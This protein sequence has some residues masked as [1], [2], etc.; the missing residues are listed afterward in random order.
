MLDGTTAVGQYIRSG[1][2]MVIYGGMGECAY[3]ANGAG[4]NICVVEPC[5]ASAWVFSI[6]LQ[7]GT[8]PIGRICHRVSI[9]KRRP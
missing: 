5:L 6:S 2:S 9:G 8:C 4:A 1:A 3:R 7:F